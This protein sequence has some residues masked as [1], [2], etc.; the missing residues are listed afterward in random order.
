[1]QALAKALGIHEYAVKKS[2]LL[3]IVLA[4]NWT[5]VNAKHVLLNL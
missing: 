3:P 4:H 2:E 5:Y 1:L